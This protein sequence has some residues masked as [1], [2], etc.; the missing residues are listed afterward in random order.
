M[1]KCW[2][3]HIALASKNNNY[4][5]C[6]SE[7]ACPFNVC[8]H[9]IYKNAGL[10]IY[11][12]KVHHMALLTRWFCKPHLDLRRIHTQHRASLLKTLYC[13]GV[14]FEHKLN[15]CVNFTW[16][17]GKKIMTITYSRFDQYVSVLCCS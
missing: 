12:H 6:E 2:F 3:K 15:Y 9:V 17:K 8:M 1:L 13:T 10:L 14:K 5:I 4:S 11:A 16:N 7:N